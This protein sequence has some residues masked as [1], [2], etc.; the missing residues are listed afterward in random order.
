MRARINLFARRA[1]KAV[2]GFDDG[3]CSSFAPRREHDLVPVGV[4]YAALGRRTATVSSRSLALG[5][6]AG[7]AFRLTV[8]GDRRRC[9][10]ARG[11][12]GSY[13][14]G[15]ASAGFVSYLEEQDGSRF[16]FVARTPRG[17][18]WRPGSRWGA[19]ARSGSIVVLILTS[20]L[21]E[22]IVPRILSSVGVY[23]GSSPGVDPGFA[24]A[25][26]S[27]GRLLARRDLRLIYGG[28]RVGLMGVLADAAL[29]EGGVVHGVITSALKDKEVAH[30]GL[31]TL[32]VVTTMHERKAAMADRS[33][34][35]VMLPGGFGTLDEF[36]EVLTWSQLAI[37]TKPCGIL[38]VNGF[39]DPLLELFE[40]AVRQRFVRPEHRDTIVI[41]PDPESMIDR[42]CAWTPVSVDKWLDRHE[43]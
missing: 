41:E 33:D 39:F 38:N 17:A 31:T 34:A 21:P 37:H 40:L 36:F 27:L 7:G 14:D 16:R 4:L 26:D 5:S 28:G 12:R 9:R 30:L 32:T 19:A 6:Q 24:E 3:L 18:A 23:C 42:L 35:F 43:G 11:S 2:D 10:R 25:A 13:G 8:G 1:V 22:M 15:V 20:P 29:A